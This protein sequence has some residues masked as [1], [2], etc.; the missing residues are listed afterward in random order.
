VANV[1]TLTMPPLAAEPKADKEAHEVTRDLYK[2]SAPATRDVEQS[3]NLSNCPIASILAALA[4]T[5]TGQQHIQKMIVGHRGTVVTDLSG[6]AGDLNSPP[7]DNKIISQRYFTVKLDN[8]SV[9][10]SDVFY[11]FEDRDESL[12]Y[13]RSPTRALWPSVIEKAYAAREGSYDKLSGVDITANEF[14]KV[15]VGKDPVVLPITD[16]TDLSE[17]RT[18]AAAASK[19]PAIGASKAKG[20]KRVTSWHGLAILGIH[21]ATIELYDPM[22]RET[23]K[24]SLKEF[25]DDF[26]A[27]L[28]GEP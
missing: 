15:I 2:G 10:V 7:K 4:H 6:V 14:W 26:Q 13:M 12:I 8:K 24:L 16:K 17:I 3:G 9:D 19:V 27:I 22:S 5:P 1:K 20:T 25:R 18:V 11:T 23:I 28:S 21:D